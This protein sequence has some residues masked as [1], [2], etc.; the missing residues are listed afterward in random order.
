MSGRFLGYTYP[1]SRVVIRPTES[2]VLG[3]IVLS[4]LSRMLM[5]IMQFRIFYA[6]KSNAHEVKEAGKKQLLQLI[7]STSLTPDAAR[8]AIL[9]QKALSSSTD[10]KRQ[11]PYQYLSEVHAQFYESEED[12]SVLNHFILQYF[13]K[14][15][16][17]LSL[18]K[19]RVK[20]RVRVKVR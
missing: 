11:Q 2:M 13:L 17:Q 19:I 5:T 15:P 14:W 7:S 1:P 6:P 10:I 20:F 16:R 18:R 12:P 4:R 3:R 8:L 9:E